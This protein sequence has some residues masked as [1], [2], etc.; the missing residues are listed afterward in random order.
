MPSINIDQFLIDIDQLK[1]QLDN[2]QSG[3]LNLNRM[4]TGE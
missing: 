4:P 1:A 2:A 3:K